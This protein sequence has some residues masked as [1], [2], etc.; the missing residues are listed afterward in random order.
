MDYCVAIY[1]VS[2]VLQKYPVREIV[3]TTDG[4]TRGSLSGISVVFD[5][6]YYNNHL[7]VTYNQQ[8]DECCSTLAE[9]KAI[10]T[11]VDMIN[12][13]RP[14]CKVQFRTDSKSTLDKIERICDGTVKIWRT[15]NSE[16]M[17]YVCLDIINNIRHEIVHQQSKHNGDKLLT[18]ND[19]MHLLADNLAKEALNNPVH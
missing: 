19:E 7:C 14:S 6:V 5:I 4:S 12:Y 1:K 3:V 18:K 17:Y 8:I 10:S 15:R 9:A 13:I 16:V 11:A 2:K